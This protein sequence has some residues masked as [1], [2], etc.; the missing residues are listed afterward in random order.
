M[1]TQPMAFRLLSELW[2]LYQTAVLYRRFY[3]C[4]L[5]IGYYLVPYLLPTSLPPAYER[6]LEL[7]EE[8]LDT[9]RRQLQLEAELAAMPKDTSD[10][11][12]HGSGV[13]STSSDSDDD[14]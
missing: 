1:Q 5:L 2:C 10:S 11:D 8:V 6:L 4:C 12:P 9:D 3:L 14:S 7:G 13:G